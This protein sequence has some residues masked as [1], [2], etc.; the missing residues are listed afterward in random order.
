M[1]AIREKT[2]T[3]VCSSYESSKAIFGKRAQ[4]ICC[5]AV[6]SGEPKDQKF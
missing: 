4:T 3:S 5:N 6:E 1:T 2:R